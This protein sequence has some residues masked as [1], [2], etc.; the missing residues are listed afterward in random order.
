MDVPLYHAL[1]PTNLPELARLLAQQIEDELRSR[2]PFLMMPNE[3]PT[4]GMQPDKTDGEGKTVAYIG[5]YASGANF[6]QHNGNRITNNYNFNIS[7]NICTA[8]GVLLK[9]VPTE[10]ARLGDGVQMSPTVEDPN[11]EGR[12]SSKD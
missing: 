8:D 5:S 12:S 2:E 7:L 11:S 10:T 6:N 3:A 9:Q 4:S 1:S